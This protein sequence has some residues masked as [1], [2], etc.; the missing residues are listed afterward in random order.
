MTL[1]SLVDAYGYLAVLVGTFIEGETILVLG[2]FA[3][4]RGYLGLPW[5]ILA[6][7]IGSLCGDQLFFF[8]GRWHG[9]A[10]LSK[11]PTWKSRVNKAQ[12]L[13]E[14]F[15][16][17]LILAFRFLYGLRTVAPFVIGMSS[18]PTVEFIF[19]NA[20][21]A[22]VWAAAV[23]TGGYLFGS[24]LEILI[25]NIKHYEIQ[26]L[27]A[28]AAIGVLIWVIYFYRRSKRKQALIKS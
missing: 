18:V 15:R 10:I 17:P 2:G 3:A 28:I 16:I 23:G 4:A 19:L 13:L 9:K 1:E 20:A 25:G 21:G 5:V 7:F 6:A 22:L 11:R 26:I 27:G 8:L 24:A 12:K 14:R